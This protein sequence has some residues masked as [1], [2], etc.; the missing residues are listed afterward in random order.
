[1]LRLLFSLIVACVGGLPAG[2]HVRKGKSNEPSPG[3]NSD[4]VR[5]F[6]SAVIMAVECSNSRNSN[7]SS[8]RR[9]GVVVVAAAA[10]AIKFADGPASF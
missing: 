10:A 6:N 2:P 9:G 4:V 3:S 1:M 5:Y 8:P 7:H